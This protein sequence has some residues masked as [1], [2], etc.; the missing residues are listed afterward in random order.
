M[1]SSG[2]F[3][4]V[5]LGLIFLVASGLWAARRFSSFSQLPLHYGPS[6]KATRMGSRNTAIW[7]PTGI[8]ASVIVFNL[9]LV[10]AIDADQAEGASDFGVVFS[11]GVIVATQVFILWLHNRWANGRG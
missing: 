10:T 6:L 1:I 3:I 2:A 4:F 9:A 5:A 7:L 8:M 11:T